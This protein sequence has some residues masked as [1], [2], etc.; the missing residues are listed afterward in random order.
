[1]KG[2]NDSTP[3]L[4]LKSKTGGKVMY[5]HNKESLCLTERQTDHVYKAMEKGDMI[6]TKTMISEMT[7]DQDNNPYKRVVLNNIYKIP[8]SCPEMKNCPIFSDNVKYI[9][10][11]QRTTQN[12]N[13]DTLDYRNHKDLYLQLKEKPFLALDIDFSLYPDITKARY[14]DVYEDIYAE[15]VY[16]SKFDKNSDLSTTYLGQTDMTRNTK[17]KAEE[18]FPITGQGFASGKLLDGT[19]CQ[20]LLDTGATKSYMSKSYYLQCKTLHTL[21]KFSSNTQRIQV[22][23]GQYVSVLFV[24]PVIIDIHGHRFEIFTLV[25][26]IHDNVDLVMGMKNIFE[27]E[28]VIDSRESCFSFL[29][30]SIPL[31][32]VMTVEI[33]PASQKMVMVDAPFVEE[34]PGMAMVKILDIKEQTTNMIKLKFIWNKAVLKIKNKTHETITF[35]RTDMMGVVDL[36][37]LGF[38]KIK[39]EVLQEHLSRHYHF[40]LADDVCDQYNSL[41]NLMRK[42]EEKSEGKFPWLDDTDK[43]KHMTD[44]EILDKYINLDNSCLTKAEKEQVRDLLYQ[45]KDAF[46]LRDKI[47]LC[48]NIEIEID[49]IDKSPFFI[50]PFHANEDDK[51]ILD[52]EMKQLCYLGILK[53]GFSAYSSPVMLIS[54]KMTKGKRVVTDFRH[55]NMQIAKNNLAYPLLKDRF[56]M[57]GNSKCEVMSVLNLKDAFH[58]LRLTENSKKFCGILPYF[59]SPSY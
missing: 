25:S 41:V 57:L 10:H 14:L 12:L 31:F 28:G 19:E 29:S 3:F 42:E 7:Q 24:I 35:G 48:P 34:L 4:P 49:V 22:G 46:S 23:N 6:N 56:S 32:Q 21:P 39:Q 18:R 36:R 45:Y 58:S 55:L 53:E 47:G 1:M 15:M 20:I 17:I 27:L 44:R 54:R 52:K 16:A 59:G 13:F 50:R 5:I 38:Y 11:D 33:A 8:E 43:R 37:S 40:D 26:E 2:K 51:V 30:R 9:Q